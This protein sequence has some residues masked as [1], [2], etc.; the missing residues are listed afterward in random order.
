MAFCFLAACLCIAFYVS[1]NRVISAQF[2]RYLMSSRAAG[3]EQIVRRMEDIYAQQGFWRLDS[4]KELVRS[5]LRNGEALSLLDTDKRPLWATDKEEAR[6]FGSSSRHHMMMR[7]SVPKNASYL[8]QVYPILHEGKTVGYMRIGYFADTALNSE[9]AAFAASLRANAAWASLGGFI[10]AGL[11]AF[12]LA[13]R[14]AKPVQD[15]TKAA[16]ALGRNNLKAR[17]QEPAGPLELAELAEAFNGLAQSLEEQHKLRARLVNDVSHEIRTPL[18]GLLALT[19]AYADGVIVPDKES[20]AAFRS[21]ILR[22]AHLAKGL[23][24]LCQPQQH[25]EEASRPS[26]VDVNRCIISVAHV[27]EPLAKQKGLAFKVCPSREPDLAVYADSEKLRQ[28]VSALT[29]NAVQYTDRGGLI[30]LRA[31]KEA[32]QAVI[33]VEDTGIGISSEDLPAI[34]ERFYR[35]DLSRGRHTGGTGLGLTILKETAERCGWQ[36]KAESQL[37]KGSIFRIAMPILA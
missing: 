21:E 23:D 27:F 26:Y 8:E 33:E 14:I 3:H 28:A 34:F 29:A 24:R 10:L 37:G 7:R 30:A 4:G 22:L 11:L 1:L 17:L 5:A 32:S 15:I 16:R 2:S 36:I 31:K 6:S 12:M 18:N 35:A 25:E 13:S 9:D 19:D 20:L